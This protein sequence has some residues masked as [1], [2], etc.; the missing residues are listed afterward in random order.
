MASYTHNEV[1]NPST[2]PW[3][4]VD[5]GGTAL[6]ASSTLLVV[7]NSDGTETR[8]AGTGFTYAGDGTPTGG[9]VSSISRTNS[10]G[11][12][13]YETITGLSL[14]LVALTSQPDDGNR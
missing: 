2:T 13:T 1:V 12:T 3:Y 10:G 8:V 5:I 11:G 4:L 14:S 6:S 9:T 7:P